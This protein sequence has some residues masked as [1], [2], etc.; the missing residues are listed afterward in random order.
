MML[1]P[2]TVS[3]GEAFAAR[4][5]QVGIII[6]IIITKEGGFDVDGDK[7]KLNSG[8]LKPSYLVLLQPKN[9]WRMKR[10]LSSL[11]IRVEQMMM[12]ILFIRL[13]SI[14]VLMRVT[15]L[16][17]LKALTRTM[18]GFMIPWD[19]LLLQNELCCCRVWSIPSLSLVLPMIVVES[20]DAVLS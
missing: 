8:L 5:N 20:L 18:N 4:F 7:R 15:T 13:W 11:S 10:K 12:N 6:I 3:V 9:C 19:Y 14:S 1:Q 16:F 2:T 17:M